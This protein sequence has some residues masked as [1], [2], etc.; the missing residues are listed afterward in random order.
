MSI[1]TGKRRTALSAKQAKCVRLIKDAV[2]AGED[3]SR[4]MLARCHDEA[5]GLEGDNK[6]ATTYAGQNMR[7]PSFLAALSLESPE[8]ETTF[9]EVLW[10]WFLNHEKNADLAKTAAKLLGKGILVEKV[11]VSFD[12]GEFSNKSNDQLRFYSVNHRYPSANEMAYFEQHQTWP[13]VLEGKRP[14]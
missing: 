10:G 3:I 12:E 2:H 13:P 5:Y 6:L 1:G 14:N 11:H 4:E 8:S 9:K 7:R